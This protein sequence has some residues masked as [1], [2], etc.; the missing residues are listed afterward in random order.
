MTIFWNKRPCIGNLPKKQRTLSSSK[1]SST[2][3]QSAKRLPIISRTVRLAGN[4]LRTGCRG[5][6]SLYRTEL[7]APCLR[8]ILPR[9]RSL[10]VAL[11]LGLARLATRPKRTGSQRNAARSRNSQRDAAKQVELSE[12]RPRRRD[13]I[14]TDT[15]VIPFTA[16]GVV[17]SVAG[18]RAREPRTQVARIPQPYDRKAMSR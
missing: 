14:D 4:G 10:P 6:V 11:S 3:Q 8:A 7:R 9:I 5:I 12:K 17:L 13:A 16:V 18:G 1:N 15:G 2:W